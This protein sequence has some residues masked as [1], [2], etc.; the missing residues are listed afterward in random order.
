M[1]GLSAVDRGKM[2]RLLGPA[3]EKELAKV[4]SRLRAFQ[5]S[6]LA[7]ES[8]RDAL[9]M[10]ERG[11]AAGE[12]RVIAKEAAEIDAAR[13]RFRTGMLTLITR[14][15]GDDV[16]QTAILQQLQDSIA[17]SDAFE[18]ADERLTARG[19]RMWTRVL[20]GQ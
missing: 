3:G 19:E 9:N 6:A 18:D 7:A 5:R 1:D 8:L 15:M 11:F 13:S 14:E 12:A 20:M 2:R 16:D 4:E 17:A 10:K